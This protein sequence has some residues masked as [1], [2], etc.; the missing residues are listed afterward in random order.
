MERWALPVDVKVR[1][2][3]VNDTN[4][5]GR[6]KKPQRT[7]CTTSPMASADRAACCLTLQITRQPPNIAT[8]AAQHQL[9]QNI[10]TIDLLAAVETDRLENWRSCLKPG[11]ESLGS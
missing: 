1:N 11:Q 3:P 10:R 6:A 5:E 9:Y 2:T 7:V 8:F 4:L